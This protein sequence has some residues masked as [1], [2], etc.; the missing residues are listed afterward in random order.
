VRR[1]RR[2]AALGVCTAYAGSVALRL[3]LARATLLDDP[4]I[5]MPRNDSQDGAMA[6]AR[7]P[8]VTVLQPILSGDPLLADLL[9]EN[10][11]GHPDARFRWLVDEDDPLGQQICR[12][13]AETRAHVEVVVFPPVEPGAN[14]KVFKLAR[15]LRRVEDNTDAQALPDELIA[16]LDDDTVLP[17]GALGATVAALDR[18][19]LVT[20][21]PWYRSGSTLW[22]RLVAGFVNGNAAISYLPLARLAPPVTINGMFYLTR[23]DTL[24]RLGGFAAIE[25]SLCDDLELA[26]L[27]RRAGGTIVQSTVTHPLATTVPD[28]TSYLRLQRRWMVFAGRLFAEQPEPRTIGLVAL[29]SLLP[30]TAAV[31]AVGDPVALAAV[32]VTVAGK[33]LALAA[34]RR[35]HL[36]TTESPATIAAEIVADLIQPAHAAAGFVRPRRIQWRTRSIRLDGDGVNYT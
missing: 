21:L 1:A 27:Y 30:L 14:P 5:R 2:R 8:A 31:L 17:P 4:P 34:L 36:G 23:R 10:A 20:G 18:G 15:A 7:E 11:D 3:W 28:L 19:D 35:K 25:R 6:P 33:A 26:R 29:P 13:L 24:E 22:S 12:H 32:G 9:A 16:V